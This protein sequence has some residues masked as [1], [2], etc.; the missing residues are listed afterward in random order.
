MSTLQVYDVWTDT[1]RPA[2]EGDIVYLQQIR[3]AYGEIRNM[4]EQAKSAGLK[5]V[6]LF[7]FEDVHA[8]LTRRLR[9]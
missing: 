3:W 2:D 9:H 8:E 4:I 7:F 5:S 6:P 1:M